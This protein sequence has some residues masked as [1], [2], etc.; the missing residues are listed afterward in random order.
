MTKLNPGR[1][2][3]TTT[4]AGKLVVLFGAMFLAI[5]TSI[6]VFADTEK[7]WEFK[8]YLDDKHIGEHSFVVRDDANTQT[9]R[10]QANF[11]VKILFVT[12][13]SYQHENTET[14]QNGCLS[15]IDASTVVNGK[16]SSVEGRREKGA[17]SMQTNDSA[18]LLDECVSTFAYWDRDFLGRTQLL[19]SQTGELKPVKVSRLG[20]ELYTYKNIAI[21]ATRYEIVVDENP[22]SLWYAQDGR[23]L[24]LETLAKGGRVLRYQPV[25]VPDAQLVLS[26]I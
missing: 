1:N 17:F 5:I 25:D 19:N 11:D 18:T 16:L 10:S 4:P 24:G 15:K 8:V 3:K 21:E 20:Q 26:G 22:I 12:A 6:S 13:F 14:W 2:E 9:I 7:K 23:W